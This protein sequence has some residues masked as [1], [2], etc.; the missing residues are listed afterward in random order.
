[1]GDDDVTFVANIADRD[2]CDRASSSGGEASDGLLAQILG[3]DYGGILGEMCCLVVVGPE[4]G[5]S[6]VNG[7]G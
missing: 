5:D 1:V 7:G 3:G 2:G 4:R 6:E